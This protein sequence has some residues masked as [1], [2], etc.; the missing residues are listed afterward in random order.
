M[1]RANLQI[2]LIT[3]SVFLLMLPVTGM[4]P[5]FAELTSGRYPGL[6]VFDRHLFMSANMVGALL[7]VPLAGLL[8]DRLG[9]R[10]PLCRSCSST[11]ARC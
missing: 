1:A 5:V 6:P 8:S 11:T 4:V 9:C 3:V 2:A 10:R 7:F